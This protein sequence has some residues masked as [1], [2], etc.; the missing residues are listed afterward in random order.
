MTYT[1][2][3]NLSDSWTFEG[4]PL[5]DSTGQFILCLPELRDLVKAGDFIKNPDGEIYLITQ[6]NSVVL[7]GVRCL[8]LYYR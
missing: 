7:N 5:S 1:Y 6:E 8:Q 2:V 3:N 4:E